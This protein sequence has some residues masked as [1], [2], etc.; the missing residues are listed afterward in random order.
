LSSDIL[1]SNEVM[2]YLLAEAVVFAVAAFAAYSAV[3]ILLGWDFNSFSPAQF[4][5]EKRAYLL[6]SVVGF[7]FAVKFLLLPYFAY[8]VDRLSLLIPGA[9]CAAGVIGGNDYGYAL[10]GT[11]VAVAFLMG[12]WLL[13]NRLDLR[14]EDYPY[15]RANTVLFLAVF[16]VMGAELLLDWLYFAN[17]T[18]EKPVSCC[19][20]TFGQ[21]GGSN[22]L[23]FGLDTPKLLLLFGL[24][25]LLSVVAALGRY[26][27]T[28]FIANLLFLFSGYYAL[29]YFFGTYVYELPTHKCP[30]C[31]LQGEYG[32]VGYLF[33][34]ALLAGSFFGMNAPIVGRLEA[35]AGAYARKMSLRFNTLFVLLCVGYVVRYY[36]KNGVF[37]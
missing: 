17:L 34:G 29:V 12:S 27:V 20:V 14:A 13:V 1:L 5:L 6:V 35:A 36:L 23:P 25:Y 2:I 16:A 21:Q 37:L 10:L 30:F 22:P 3:R 24:F 31:M 26:G 19:S 18:T 7:A 15:L 32:Y 11:K 4:A 28:G 33:W 9:M 8:G